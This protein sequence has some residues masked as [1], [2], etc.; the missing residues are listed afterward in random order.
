MEGEERVTFGVRGEELL[1]EE[2]KSVFVLRVV[3]IRP[4]CTVSID[5]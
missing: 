2:R 4:D 3:L 1:S 5:T